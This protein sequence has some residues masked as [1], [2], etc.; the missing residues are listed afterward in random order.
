MSIR[1]VTN[2]PTHAKIPPA[3]PFVHHFK[4]VEGPIEPALDQ[5][6]GPELSL[7]YQLESD[8]ISIVYMQLIKFY[9]IFIIINYSELF[10]P[11]QPIF[12]HDIC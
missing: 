11:F 7:G 8:E 12:H 9:I 3:E 4:R 10:T 5:L 6:N 1:R 2:T